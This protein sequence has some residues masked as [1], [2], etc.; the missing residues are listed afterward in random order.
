MLKSLDKVL[1][2]LGLFGLVFGFGVAV[3]EYK[4]FP[5]QVARDGA[6]AARDLQ[7][8]WKSYLHMEPTKYLFPARVEGEGVTVYIPDRAQHGLTFMTGLFDSRVGLQLIDMDGTV[9]HRWI[10]DYDRIW[11]EAGTGEL[12]EDGEYPFNDWDTLIQGAEVLPDGSV[13]FNYSDTLLVKLDQ[14]GAA[15]WLLPYRTHHSVFRSEDGTFWLSRQH[16]VPRGE[17]APPRIAP[18]YYQEMALQIA[19]SGEILREFLLNELLIDNGM[20]GLL[21]PT[22]T[23]RVT[24]PDIDFTHLNDVEVLQAADAG[25][26]PLFEAG[27]VL[28]SMRNLNLLFVFDPDSLK[29]KWHQTGPWLRQHDPDFLPDGTIAVY[30]NRRDHTQTGA[31]LGGSDIMVVNPATGQ[32]RVVYEGS[33]DRPF[34]SAVMGMQQYLPN[35]NF[36]I[37]ET[38]GGRAFEVDKGGEIVWE[39]VN[40]FDENR[41]AQVEQATRLPEGFFSVEHWTC[42]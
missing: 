26:F 8:N 18:P 16:Y 11:R 38:K 10:P 34:Y 31:A 15:Q 7:L 14:C 36:L 3:G 20:E 22:G 4:L 9:L 6:N 30:N 5:Y 25:K 13:V 1:F 23:G 40:R 42:G 39:Y 33:A 28:I 37:T 2:A 17:E 21:F 19:P 27:D 35:G 24:N 29:I 12:P 41:V 32:T